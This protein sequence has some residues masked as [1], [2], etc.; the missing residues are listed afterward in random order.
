MHHPR[1]IVADR[2]ARPGLPFTLS[3]IYLKSCR[4][5]NSVNRKAPSFVLLRRLFVC[6]VVIADFRIHCFI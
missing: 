1:W 3:N 4:T 2:P 6:S 5:S